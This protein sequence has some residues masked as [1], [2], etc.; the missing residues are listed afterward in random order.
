MY[1]VCDILDGGDDRHVCHRVLQ[2]KEPAVAAAAAAEPVPPSGRV[3][4][5]RG[6]FRYRSP[7]PVEPERPRNGR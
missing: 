2:S 4:K 6:S 7:S 3:R 1:A 5:G